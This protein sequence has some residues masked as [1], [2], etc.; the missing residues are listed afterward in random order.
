MSFEKSLERTSLAGRARNA[1]NGIPNFLQISESIDHLLTSDDRVLRVLDP[2]WLKSSCIMQMCEA[3]VSFNAL[4]VTLSPGLVIQSKLS[5][6]LAQN[7]SASD[8]YGFFQKRVRRFVEASLEDINFLFSR[9]K[10]CG[11][12]FKCFF[13]VLTGWCTPRTFG[14]P[15][16]HCPYCDFDLFEDVG[17][18]LTCPSFQN[19]C[20]AAVHQRHMFL[21]TENLVLLKRNGLP[22]NADAEELCLIYVHLAFMCYNKCR[23]G[24]SLCRRLLVHLIA[25]MCSQ[26]SRARNI[27]K[28]LRLKNVQL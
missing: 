10:E 18:M 2:L 22:L 4:K 21:T 13:T 9:Y 24:E 27:I 25:R 1:L 23:H 11:K 17:H 7:D 26:C 19:V 20:L 8:Y 28:S 12:K 16:H 6:A 5:I 14:Q 15:N 3:V